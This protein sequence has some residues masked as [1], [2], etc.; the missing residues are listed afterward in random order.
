MKTDYFLGLAGGLALGMVIAFGIANHTNEGD[1][2][3]I[4]KV[5]ESK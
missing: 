1:G 3:F 4:L 2:K 5:K